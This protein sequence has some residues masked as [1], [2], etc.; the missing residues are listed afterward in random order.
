M[1][2]ICFDFFFGTDTGCGGLR[3]AWARLLTL[4][5]L[6]VLAVNKLRTHEVDLVFFCTPTLPS[7]LNYLCDLLASGLDIVGL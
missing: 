4:H 7:G 5:L 2:F 6:K 1:V 3:E